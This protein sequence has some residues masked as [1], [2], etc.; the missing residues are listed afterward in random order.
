MIRKSLIGLLMT[1]ASATAATDG[2][3]LRIDSAV[4]DGMLRVVP[5]IAAPAGAR[6]RYEVISTKEGGSGRSNTNQSGTVNVGPDGSAKLSSLSVGV[7]PQDRYVITVK[8]FDGPK[9]VAEEVL[10]YPQ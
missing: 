2:Y 6:L 3:Q 5:H 8:V 1:T 7:T 10:R 4:G 9:L